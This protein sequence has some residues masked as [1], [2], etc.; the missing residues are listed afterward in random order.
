MIPEIDKKSVS[1]DGKDNK[2]NTSTNS[3]SIQSSTTKYGNI[4][5]EVKD[6]YNSLLNDVVCTIAN[7]TEEFEG[8]SNMGQ[9]LIESI[10]YGKYMMILTKSG[11][12]T[13]TQPI[14]I[15]SDEVYENYTM[16]SV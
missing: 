6:T 13:I 14:T 15:D 16:E 1:D 3:N 9:I 10:P 4:L 7:D 8:M 2:K 11:L 5:I 12:K